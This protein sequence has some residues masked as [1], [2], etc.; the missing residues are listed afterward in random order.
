MQEGGMVH[1][2]GADIYKEMLSIFLQVTSPFK[3]Y[4]QR[5]AALEAKYSNSKIQSTTRDIRQAVSGV[6]GEN[7]S[8]ESLQVAMDRM[9]ELSTFVFPL[10]EGAVG[11]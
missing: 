10:A 8:L 5:L 2:D 4:Q 9:Q 11:V 6:S 1:G 7:P 3:P